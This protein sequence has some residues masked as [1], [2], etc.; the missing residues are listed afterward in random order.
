MRNMIT[1]FLCISKLTL[2][3]KRKKDITVSLLENE[4]HLKPYF[5]YNVGLADNHNE[6]ASSDFAFILSSVFSQY[7]DIMHGISTKCLKVENL[8]DIIKLV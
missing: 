1:I 6:A 2:I 7:S 5:D 3:Y 8:F 4:T